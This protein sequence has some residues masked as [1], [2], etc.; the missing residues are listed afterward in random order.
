VAVIFDILVAAISLEK[1]LK[2]KDGW[3]ESQVVLT[4]RSMGREAEKSSKGVQGIGRACRSQFRFEIVMP[5]L[6]F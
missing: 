5:A 2:K 4:E 3:L 1:K 6:T